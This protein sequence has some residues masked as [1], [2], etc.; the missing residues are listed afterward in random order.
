MKLT[1]NIYNAFTCLLVAMMGWICFSCSDDVDGG[2]VDER[3][4][5]RVTMAVVAKDVASTRA[6]GDFDAQSNE[7]IHS[8]VVAFVKADGTVAEVVRCS[9]EETGR[10]EREISVTLSA[11][12][13]TA[14]AF[15][16]IP[17]ANLTDLVAN[18]LTKN[19]KIT[20]AD[21]TSARYDVKADKL[22][23]DSQIP[24]SGFLAEIEV[25]ANGK[26]KVADTEKTV[27]E[28]PVVRMV[29]KL[30]FSFKNTTAQNITIKSIEVKPTASG[31]ISLF[32]TLDAEGKF[33]PYYEETTT[34]FGSKTV[35][36]ETE[37]PPGW[38]IEP[39]VE[40]T[41]G[42]TDP[43][44]KSFSF[45]LREV[46][47]NHPTGH[48]PITIKYTKEGSTTAEEM[49]A[50]LYDLTQINRNDWI[51][52]PI[53][54]SDYRLKLDVEF[55][56]PIGGYP[57]VNWEDKDNEYYVRFAT[58]GWFSI[59]ALVYDKGINS[60][61]TLDPKHVHISVLSVEDA[62]KQ[63][64]GSSSVKKF[65]RKQ[66]GE[67]LITTGE[68]TGEINTGLTDGDSSVVTI[69]VRIQAVDKDGNLLTGADDKPLV[70]TFKRKI[71]FIYKK[72]NTNN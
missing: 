61:I 38:I 24:M 49:T 69:E 21:L 3:P 29:G 30:E 44:V 6:L 1:H 58:G 25:L 41:E 60:D 47:S 26:V 37:N 4:Q 66:P 71:H 62:V 36:F 46:A 11:G 43:E 17:E 39:T 34:S 16:N 14:Y 64:E 9:E 56:P 23:A 50:L 55:Y 22:T 33:K 20:I 48:F 65:F 54:L 57:P 45:Y 63:E 72:P 59:S 13:Y 8:C 70:T 19:S 7:L 32:P 53:T 42:N 2:G 52:V 28:I 35:D 5:A 31:E 10:S 12:E 68:L 67:E 51:R 40:P 27:I 15:A 18:L